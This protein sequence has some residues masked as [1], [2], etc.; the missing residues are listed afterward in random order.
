MIERHLK[1][2]PAGSATPR[3]IRVVIS[4]PTPTPTGHY[5]STLTIEGFAAPY[6]APFDQV[7]PLGAVLAAAA[8]APSILA[9]RTAGGRLTWLDGEE[10][11]FPLL[12]PPRCHYDLR[13]G[14]GLSITIAPPIARG[15]AWACLVTIESSNGCTDRWIDGPSWAAALERAAATVPEILREHGGG[16]EAQASRV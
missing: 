1:Y 4:A 16:E 7:D 13:D 12:T 2:W 14:G 10:L 3:P 5:Q 6:S 15:G 11:G 8:I 9:M